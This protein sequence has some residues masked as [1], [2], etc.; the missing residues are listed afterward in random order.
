MDS[1]NIKRKLYNVKI[2]WTGTFF[3]NFET[4][5]VKTWYGVIP[6]TRVLWDWVCNGFFNFFN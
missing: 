6:A 3:I 1:K 4:E 2:V 5:L